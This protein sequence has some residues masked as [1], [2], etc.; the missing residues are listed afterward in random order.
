MLLV[1]NLKK[2]SPANSALGMS[3]VKFIYDAALCKQVSRPCEVL[4]SRMNL[5]PT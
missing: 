3:L 5:G 1:A 2:E 4:D